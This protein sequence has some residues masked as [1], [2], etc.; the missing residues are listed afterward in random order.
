MNTSVSEL[1]ETLKVITAASDN[2][3]RLLKPFNALI[4]QSGLLNVGAAS[5]R[6]RIKLA[7]LIIKL[8]EELGE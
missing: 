2:L 3:N 8:K 1:K 6:E 5:L 4:A 7:Q